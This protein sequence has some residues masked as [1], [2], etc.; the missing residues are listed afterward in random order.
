MG[1]A[2]NR[3]ECAHFSV[4][5]RAEAGLFVIGVLYVPCVIALHTLSRTETPG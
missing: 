5:A 4:L 2:E 3:A 1:E